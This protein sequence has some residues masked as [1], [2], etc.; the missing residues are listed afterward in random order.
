MIINADDFGYS[1]SNNRAIVDCFRRGYCSSTTLMT[2]M[3]GFEEAC[4][5]VHEHKLLNH[6]GIH[7]VLTEGLPLTD[8]IKKCSRFCNSE[9]LFTM[10]RNQRFFS[11]TSEEKEAVTDELR[12][13]IKRCRQNGIRITHA[14]SHSNAHEE[15]AIASIAIQLCHEE[16]IP[17]LRL[18]RNCGQKLYWFKQIY[19]NVLNFKIKKNRLARTKYFGSVAD[20]IY[21]IKKEGL[22]DN[23]ES[24]EVMIHPGYNMKGTLVDTYDGRALSEIMERLSLGLVAESFSGHR[25]KKC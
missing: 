13:Q 9:G 25:W 14:D 3:P 19:R 10:S 21:L 11:L 5:L 22:H 24:M 6:T 18:A 17:Y 4:Q 20:C 1:G 8:G 16:G 23:I 12:A 15:W 7:L 2:N